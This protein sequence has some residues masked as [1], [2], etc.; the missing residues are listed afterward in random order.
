MQTK[1]TFGA[2]FHYLPHAT[3]T[4]RLALPLISTYPSLTKEE[5]YY[6]F[7]NEIFYEISLAPRNDYK[8][9]LRHHDQTC[10]I[11]LTALDKK[12]DCPFYLGTM[13]LYLL[14]NE[15]GYFYHGYDVTYQSHLNNQDLELAAYLIT[16][17]KTINHDD[18]KDLLAVE[19]MLIILKEVFERLN[20]PLP[21]NYLIALFNQQDAFINCDQ[22]MPI[23]NNFPFPFSYHYAYLYHRD[24]LLAL[25]VNNQMKKRI[26]NVILAIFNKDNYCDLSPSEFAYRMS[27][28]YALDELDK[29]YAQQLFDLIQQNRLLLAALKTKDESQFYRL[30]LERNFKINKLFLLKDNHYH[31]TLVNYLA[32][33]YPKVN[34][35]TPFLFASG[36]MLFSKEEINNLTFKGEEFKNYS[37]IRLTK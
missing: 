2:Y 16:L 35:L 1:E 15:K 30:N 29:Y 27:L 22:N 28:S 20:S 21:F 5:S 14:L 11:D 25:S 17:I 23:I 9:H 8:I 3:L 24:S 32:L 33:N 13:Y 19:E 31:A 12:K 10:L 18:N 6:F 37:L 4:Y 26:Q 7:P 36:V 34:Y